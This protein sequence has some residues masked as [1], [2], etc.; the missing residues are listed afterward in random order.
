MGPGRRPPDPGS[1]RRPRAAG[2]V[3]P[4]VQLIR[5]AAASSASLGDWRPLV[6]FSS[7]EAIDDQNLPISGML[8]MGS[9][10]RAFSIVALMFS[11]LESSAKK[12]LLA[13]VPSGT[14]AL[15]VLRPSSF[16]T[17]FSRNS[18]AT[19]FCWLGAEIMQP[20]TPTKGLAGLPLTS[21]I[22]AT[23]KSILLL[24]RLSQAQGPEIII[25]TSPLLTPDS[26]SA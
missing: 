17:W 21:G 10:R 15:M 16:M 11:L 9:P 6:M 23:P 3:Q 1:G 8:G 19:S 12:A 24:R 4:D 5:A 7:A 25:A 18:L 26:I 22:G 14:S 20:S 2:A 13:G